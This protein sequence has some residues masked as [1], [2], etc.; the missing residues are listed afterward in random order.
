[1]GKIE[2]VH[3]G[4]QTAKAAVFDN[5]GKKV[6]VAVRSFNGAY[7]TL[8]PNDIAFG[9]AILRSLDTLCRYY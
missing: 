4:H 2:Y 7:W 5:D 8:E 6:C 1:M 9:D 3:E